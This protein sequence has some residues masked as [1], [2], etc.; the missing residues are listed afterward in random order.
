MLEQVGLS[1]KQAIV[2]MALLE[3]GESSVLR[4]A[5]KTSIKRPTV[6]VTLEALLERGLVERIPKGGKS[7]YQAFDP[8]VVLKSFRERVDALDQAIP[9]LRAMMAGSPRKPRV[10]VYEGK[11]SI[12]RFYESEIFSGKNILALV[13]IRELRAIFSRDELNGMLYIMKAGGGNI[14]ELTDQSREADEYLIEKNRLELGGSKFLPSGFSLGI[15]LLMYGDT[16]AMISPK[17]LMAVVIEDR[18]ISASQKQF[19]EFVWK[20]C[21]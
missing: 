6:Y 4:I 13:N 21:A 1:Q 12:L 10:R 11:K 15:D 3:L 7:A 18:A 2:Y 17:N 19:F 9:E 20:S 16:V 14:R 5:Q 8:E